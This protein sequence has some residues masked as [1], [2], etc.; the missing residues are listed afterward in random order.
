MRPGGVN[1]FTVAH[2]CGSPLLMCRINPNH[3]KATS[4]LRVLI[5]ITMLALVQSSVAR[6]QNS[7]AMLT[8]EMRLAPYLAAGGT[9]DDLCEDGKLYCPGCAQCDTCCMQALAA[10][11]TA[12][13]IAER[14]LHL[15]IFRP[16]RPFEAATPPSRAPPGPPVRAPPILI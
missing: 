4:A 11:P 9:L 16:I 2:P 3:A 1:L 15:E 7:G 14:W 5:M 12:P 10:L 13:G 6:V 8:L